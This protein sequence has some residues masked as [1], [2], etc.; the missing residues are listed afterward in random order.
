MCAGDLDIL[1]VGEANIDLIM[2]GT[3]RIPAWG[4]EVVADGGYEIRLGG[5]TANFA[6]FAAALGLKTALAGAV[7]RDS[8]GDFL[9]DQLARMG[10]STEFMIRADDVPTGLTVAISGPEDRAFVTAV[11]TIDFM[12]AQLVPDE[13]LRR[14]RHLHVGS[15]F[16]QRRLQEGLAELFGRAKG[17]GLTISLDLGYDPA[18][19]W[20]GALAEVLP[21]VDVLLPNETEACAIAGVDDPR[22]AALRLSE[23]G[24]AVAV[25][26]G[27][28]GACLAV[29]GE[30]TC[31]PA[32]SVQVRDT[33]CC[34]D[35]FNAGLLWARLA[36]YDWPEALLAGNA[37]GALM[38]TV[39][40]NQAE[41]LSPTAVS[42]LAGLPPISG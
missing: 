20:D 34:G 8:F 7:G 27:E 37:A 19:K 1:A 39:V 4:E 15:F 26:M 31:K 13:A 40:G 12:R 41:I 17:A 16:L 3:P 5:S 35:A 28:E 2:V 30:I 25:K 22:Q 32:F 36:G 24:P 29:G 21:L 18:E 6:C 42:Q 33:T 23:K 38:A 11:G 9:M 14:A 10:V